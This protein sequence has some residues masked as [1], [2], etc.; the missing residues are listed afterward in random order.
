MG[1]PTTCSVLLYNTRYSRVQVVVLL[2]INSRTTACT[3]LYLVLYSNTLHVVGRGCGTVG[4]WGCGTVGLW[5]C[6]TVGLWDC[7]TVG[8]WDCG[9][10][11]LCTFWQGWSYWSWQRAH[12]VVM[13]RT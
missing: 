13:P 12:S 9:T 8:L 11:V 5:G 1:L 7:G 10:V 6:G 3:L 2:F 4:L